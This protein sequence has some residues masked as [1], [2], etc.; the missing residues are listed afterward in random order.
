MGKS[1]TATEELNVLDDINLE[2][3]EDTIG[4]EVSIDSEDIEEDDIPEM[5]D[6]E[7]TKYVLGLF[8]PNELEDGN[9]KADGL[10]RVAIKVFGV[11]DSETGIVAAPSISNAGRAT[12]TVNLQIYYKQK[13][14]RVSGSADVY[15]GNTTSTFAEHAVATAETR[16]EGRALRRALCLTKVVT[17]EEMAGADD[18]AVKSN[19]PIAPDSMINSIKAM[20]HKISVDPFKVALVMGFAVQDISEITKEQAVKISKEIGK[21]NRA[22]PL[23]K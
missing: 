21:K 20:G 6:P 5:Y 4:T 16:A 7:W 17:A 18:D 23:S 1:A 2:P 10:R 22:L 15:S 9:P 13:R 8:Q 14:F 19:S 12:V 11:F 3:V